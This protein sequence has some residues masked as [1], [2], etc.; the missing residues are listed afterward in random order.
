MECAFNS[1]ADVD[2]LEW[3]GL[4]HSCCKAAQLGL[5]HAGDKEALEVPNG[6][7]PPPHPHNY[8]RSLR[9]WSHGLHNH[10]GKVDK[11]KWHKLK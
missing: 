9:T 2:K 6:V 7:S 10:G 5:V 11:E 8:W 3:S 1:I 4:D